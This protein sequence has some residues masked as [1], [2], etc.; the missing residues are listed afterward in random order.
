MN[1]FIYHAAKGGWTANSIVNAIAQH[2]PKYAPFIQNALAAK[3]TAD[4]VLDRIAES[5]DSGYITPHQKKKANIKKSRKQA[6]TTLATGAALLSGVAGYGLSGTSSAGQAIRPSQII[7]QARRTPPRGPAPGAGATINVPP[8]P[9]LPGPQGALPAPKPQL[10]NRQAQLPYNP[11]QPPQPR[12]PRNP[13]ANRPSGPTITPPY[14][15][16]PAYNVS[17]VKN[18]GLDKKLGAIL[19]S[20]LRGQA[21]EQVV[22]ETLPKSKLAILEKAEGGLPQLLEDYS[23]IV[24]KEKSRQNKTDALKKFNERLRGSL[25]GKETERF[26][27]EYGEQ[28]EQ[29]QKNPIEQLQQETLPEL[30]EEAGMSQ[31]PV[32]SRQEG[33]QTKLGNKVTQ[34]AFGPRESLPKLEDLSLR[35][36]AFAIADYKKPNESTQAFQE[37]KVINDAINK[38]AKNIVEGK[39]FL[40][41]I[42]EIP[43]DQRNVAGMSTASDV[44]RFMA[45][46][47][48]P[49]DPLLGEDE[50][51]ELHDALMQSGHRTI[52]GLRPSPGEQN[53]YGAP[54]SPNMV[55]NMLLAVEPQLRTMK[56]PRLTGFETTKDNAK[57][58]RMLT[59][60][61]Y[62]VLSGKRIS[63]DL[64]D[65]IAK[66][67]RATAGLDIIAQAAKAGNLLA[68]K[69]EMERLMDDDEFAAALSEVMDSEYIDPS[70]IHQTEENAAEDEVNAKYFKGRASREKKKQEKLSEN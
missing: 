42:K 65:K 46:I 15:H 68:M 50:K 41:L 6:A 24:Q 1:N 70:V 28:L 66:I 11:Q 61:V 53:V 19:G 62:G 44:L 22:R 23:A 17:L 69:R 13:P 18:M 37:R 5:E 39:S 54:M 38:A 60:S 30:T 4:S 34:A 49:Y 51:Q 7:G 35:K 40:D 33:Q 57:M 14:E 55:W 58:R 21:I 67:S 9:G 45:G 12:A 26:E 27:N 10:P 43:A 56:I 20:G 32:H 63:T 8:P 52:E 47:P 29:A 64:A 2:N 48:N 59:H 16:D 31:E 3:Y 25:V 36:D